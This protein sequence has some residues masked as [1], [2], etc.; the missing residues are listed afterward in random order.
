MCDGL[1]ILHLVVWVC[2]PVETEPGVFALDEVVAEGFCGLDGDY[3]EGGGE[4]EF[5]AGDA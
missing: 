2:F 4:I 3:A 1:E 5:V